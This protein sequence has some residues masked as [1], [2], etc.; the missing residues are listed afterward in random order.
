M[1]CINDNISH[2]Q[3][4]IRDSIIIYE[5]GESSTRRW[6]DKEFEKDIGI[7]TERTYSLQPGAQPR[8]L[9]RYQSTA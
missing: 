5:R 4:G 7:G 8:D 1:S 9:T 2:K 3:T 6:L